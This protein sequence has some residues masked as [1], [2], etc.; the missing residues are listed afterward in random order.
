MKRVVTVFLTHQGPDQ[1]RRMLAFWRGLDADQ[2]W[3]IANG[4]PHDLHHVV[5]CPVVVVN[6]V[7]LRTRDHGR[8]KQSY[9]GVFQAVLPVVRALDVDFVSFVEYDEVPL[10]ARLNAD[11]IECI[12]AEEA[13]VLGLR[14]Y[15]VDGTSHHQYLDHLRDELFSNFWQSISC[16]N[17]TGVVL[18]M[19]GCGS[20]WRREAFFAVADLVPTTRIYLEMFM[21]TAAHHLGYRVRPFPA[22]QEHAMSPEISK[23]PK[24]QE[25]YRELG[26]WRMH[27]V[28][29]MW[30]E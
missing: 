24:Q 1:V 7:A 27:P 9:Q 30:D 6:D 10:T 26:A 14:L 2:E 13:D 15:R 22:E 20:F 29:E 21:P 25:F 5:D 18:S 8:E 19:L 28:K 23:L 17:D 4:G 16:R 12:N 11:M 3:I